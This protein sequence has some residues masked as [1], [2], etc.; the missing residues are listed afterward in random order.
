MMRSNHSRTGISLLELMAVVAILGVVAAV[1][2]P[3]VTGSSDSAN[4]AACYVYKGDIEIQSELWNHNTGGFP[5]A[6]LAAIGLDTDYFPGGPPTCPVDDTK[7]TINPTTG[8]V[9][10]HNH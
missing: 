1:I 7:Y 5:A 2:I 9:V 3:S 6:T 4:I 8:L 10:G